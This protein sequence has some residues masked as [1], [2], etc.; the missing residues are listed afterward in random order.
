MRRTLVSRK[1]RKRRIAENAEMSGENFYN[2]QALPKLDTSS[3]ISPDSKQPIM[4]NGA[5]GADNLPSFA[6]YDASRRMSDERPLNSRSPPIRGAG[7]ALPESRDGSERYAPSNRSPK[8][9]FGN[10]I[11]AN[12]LGQQPIRRGPSDPRMRDQFMNAR[13]GPPGPP[14]PPMGPPPMG[15]P[16]GGFRGRGYGPPRGRGG[17]APGPGPG[18]G[19][20]GPPPQGY[21]PRGAFMGGRGGPPPM[22]GGPMMR[23]NPMMGRGGPPGELMMGRG[24][25]PPQGPPPGNPPPG[26]PPQETPPNQYDIIDDYSRQTQDFS[27]QSPYQSPYGS[28]NQSPSGRMRQPSPPPP[29]P[30]VPVGQAIEMDAQTGRSSETLPGFG[31]PGNRIRASDDDVAGM[32]GLQQQ[33]QDTLERVRS[34]TSLYSQQEYVFCNF[35]PFLADPFSRYVPPRLAWARK[36]APNNAAD[37]PSPSVYAPQPPPTTHRRTASSDNYYEDID[38]RFREQEDQGLPRTLTPG[39]NGNGQLPPGEGSFEDIPEG[40]RSPAASEASHFTSVSQRGVNPNW[41]PGQA[42][43][44]MMPGRKVQQQRRD[45]LLGNNPDFEMPASSNRGRG[46]MMGRG[47]PRMPPANIPGMPNGGGGGRY[48]IPG[49]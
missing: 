7:G 22:R 14:G 39:N 6:T 20:R 38:P 37:P 49:M 13:P 27:A 2:R 5:P 43:V 30:D 21:P 26:Y 1:A 40:A 8:D 42:D 4:V 12:A 34:P 24:G 41:R 3:P 25:P 35:P 47:G 48:P 44:D 11:P 18:P 23:G 31:P 33:R 17:F 19:P 28:R 15:P 10:P 45:V 32:V 36:N 16:R 9:E 46:G 29:M